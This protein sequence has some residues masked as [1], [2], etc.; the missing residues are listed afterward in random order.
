MPE[1]PKQR[2]ERLKRYRENAEK[3]MIELEKQNAIDYHKEQSKKFIEDKM[4]G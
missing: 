4:K 2:A 3:A 1:T